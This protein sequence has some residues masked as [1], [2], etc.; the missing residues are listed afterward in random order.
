[1]TPK[2]ATSLEANILSMAPI[3][4]RFSYLPVSTPS[5]TSSTPHG[6]QPATANLL[7][8]GT[9]Q[10]LVPASPAAL[11]KPSALLDQTGSFSFA[12]I[13]VG[14]AMSAANAEQQRAAQSASGTTL[15]VSHQKH[16]F[17]RMVT[18]LLIKMLNSRELRS[19]PRAQR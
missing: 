1:M 10:G 15:E 7:S 5:L 4:A 13:N 16:A 6:L 8:T 17:V 11:A 3:A 19:Q 12:H 2:P 9:S 14:R 18:H